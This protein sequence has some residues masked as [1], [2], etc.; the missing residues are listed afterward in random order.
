MKVDVAARI[1]DIEAAEW[2]R[3]AGHDFPFLRHEFLRAAERT[4]CVSK[5]TGWSPRHI[6]IR[7]RGGNLRGAMPLYEKTHS[8]G[9]FVFDWSWAQAYHRAGVPYYPKLVSAV[10]F[11]P[12]P[13]PRLLLGDENG[14]ENAELL[15]DAAL[16]I[17]KA[18]SCSSLHVL[19]P[20]E[21]ELQVLRKAGLELRKDCQ[22]HWHNRNYRSFEDFLATF[23]S[24]KRKKA[25]RD[26][27]HVHE[28]EIAFR[29][30]KGNDMDAAI[31]QDVYEMISTTFLRRGSM[32]Y[33]DYAFFTSISRALP[34]NV[35]VVLAERRRMPVAAAIFYEGA[36]TLYG[37]YWGSDGHYDA[38]HFETCYYQGI[39]YCIANGLARFEPGTQ[40]EH[41]ISRGFV[42]VSTWSAHWLARPEFF[43]AVGQYLKEERRH[44]DRYM[45][46]VAAHSPYRDDFGSKEQDEQE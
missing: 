3:L 38:L 4:G 16:E 18:S 10:P 23:S 21:E 27:R 43:T 33:Y 9:E 13:S 35:L 34:D 30:L 41:K 7:D 5:S 37:R 20:M 17:A 46:A 2:N 29:W 22:F 28:Q 44:V 6:T 32:P 39:D 26:R 31:W 25:R 11:T 15:V 42:P 45:D 14:G 19:F 12:A 36:D 40:G 24:A 8:W 1:S